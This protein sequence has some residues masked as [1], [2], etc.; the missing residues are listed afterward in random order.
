MHA[1]K[2]RSTSYRAR[3]VLPV[4]RPP[5]QGGVVTVGGG[6]ILAVKDGGDF[7]V[8]LGDVVLA[9]GFVNVHCHL[10]LSDAEPIRSPPTSFTAWLQCV[11]E[12]R[13]SKPPLSFEAMKT[14]TEAMKRNGTAV[15]GDVALGNVAAKTEAACGLA[16]VTFGEVLGLREDRYGPLMDEIGR[17]VGKMIG[18]RR[19]GF[20]PHA[21]YSAAAAV[22]RAPFAG[23]RCT[24]WLESPEEV[25]FL[26]TGGGPMKAFLEGI[27]AWP[28]SAPS[29][30]WYADP[31][32]ELLGDP[33]DWLLV[34]AN[35]TTDADLEH[36][37]R[38]SN[39]KPLRIAYCPRT[40]ATFGFNEYPLKLFLDAG[41]VVGLGTDSLVSNPDL[42]VFNEA[43][44]VAERFP[45]FAGEGLLR[46]LTLDGARLLGV[47]DEVGSLTPGKSAAIVVM[48]DSGR[49]RDAFDWPRFFSNETRATGWLV[50]QTSAAGTAGF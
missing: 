14:A 9:P 50:D 4:D 44:F 31:W 47:E 18:S 1:R 42:D 21:P 32:A 36:A 2:G 43:V 25:E 3:W 39:G 34:H 37:I 19:I 26:N 5:I 17:G 8:D 23:P 16:G 45:R 13:R 41:C 40:H 46:M 33:S 15:L 6:R 49:S 7:D 30:R 10:D 22:Y 27:G 29:G 20:S 28:A 38:L 48:T 35:F 11:V 12:Q 24:H